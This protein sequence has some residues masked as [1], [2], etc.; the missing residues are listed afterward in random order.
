MPAASRNI[1][2]FPLQLTLNQ[3][4]IASGADLSGVVSGLRK[5]TLYLMIVDDEGKA[6]LVS[7]SAVGDVRSLSFSAPMTLT[8]RPGSAVQLLIAIAS[9]GP[10]RNLPT[11]AR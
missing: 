11:K 7:S 4:E 9:D 8:G 1:P 10:L 6:K 5:D 2:N 3:P